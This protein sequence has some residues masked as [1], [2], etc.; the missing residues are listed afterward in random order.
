MKEYLRPTS[1]IDY[2][3]PLVK[4]KA[5]ELCR[6]IDKPVDI[7]KACFE[8]VRDQIRHGANVENGTVTCK[9]SEVLKSGTGY[10]YAQAHLLSPFC[11]PIRLRLDSVTSVSAGS[12]T[13]PSIICMD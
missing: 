11:G 1:V 13:K 4:A 7:A 12:I 6:R 8:W 3:H 10:C 2:T 9:A 5:K